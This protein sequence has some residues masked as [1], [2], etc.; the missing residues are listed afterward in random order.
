MKFGKTLAVRL[1]PALREHCIN[2]K[3]LKGMLRAA[4]EELR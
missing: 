2:Y 4:A 3:M 1:K